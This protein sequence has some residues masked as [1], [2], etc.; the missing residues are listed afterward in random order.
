MIKTENV[1]MRRAP[2][3]PAIDE[4]V[5]VALVGTG[6]R[7]RTKYL[8][9]IESLTNWIDICAV[10]DPVKENADRMAQA[11]DVPAF[12]DIHEL[13]KARPMEAAFIV[14]PSPSH[15][16]I[17]V[18]LSSHGIH[19][20]TETP[21]A[22][23][24]CQGREMITAARENNVIVRVAENFF[25]YPIDRFAQL[26]MDSEYLGRIRR[27]FAYNDHTGFH[28]NSRWIRFAGAHPLWVQAISH[29]IKTPA[30]RTTPERFHTSET[31]EG[32]YF[33]F[34]D[35]FLVVDQAAN[36]KSLLGRSPRPGYTEWQGER[37]ALV[38]QAV[39]Y[40][41]SSKTELRRCGDAGI[42]EQNG[43]PVMRPVPNEI[44]AVIHEKNS[45]SWLRSYAE[46][47]DGLLEYVNPLRPQKPCE[48]RTVEYGTPLMG[49]M[50]DFALTIR[51]LRDSE[52]DDNDGL[53][54]LMMDIG[55]NESALNEGKRIA[56][57]LE[58]DL[59][60]DAIVSE[61]LR[62][63][64]GVDPMDIEAMLAI[65]YPKP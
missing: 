54:S 11:L 37:G 41:L 7:S 52:F 12:Y 44:T 48:H 13:V 20:M 55:A 24:I 8:P 42:D 61:S 64:F 19:N 36:G 43:I 58:G 3:I 4:P 18:Y 22:R 38:H 32:R 25:R 65:S 53:V 23:M 40:N 15:H 14:T 26:V 45:L 31:F 63:A 35:E 16:S 28:N 33:M 2:E 59:E 50:T 39:D 49:H 30:H 56:L 60:A 10:C 17:S 34:P 51:G 29:T 21:L 47:P 1:L 62:N 27:I 57:P 5:K 46:T 6:N 9:L